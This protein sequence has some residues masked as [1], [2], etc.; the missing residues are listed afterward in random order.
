MNYIEEN[1][2]YEKGENDSYHGGYTIHETNE[3]NE[4]RYLG[5]NSDYKS[6]FEDKV[7]PFG[8]FYRKKNEGQY[9]E[10]TKVIEGGLIDNE[11]FDKLFFSVGK[12]EKKSYKTKTRKIQTKVQK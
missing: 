6:Q 8:L 7:I 5:G 3:T 10:N 2:I 4:N 9:N 11:M 1:I 12:I